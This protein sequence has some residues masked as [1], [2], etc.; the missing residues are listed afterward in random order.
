MNRRFDGFNLGIHTFQE[1]FVGHDSGI[2]SGKIS[3]A[4]A[5]AEVIEID[6]S[7][8]WK[9]RATE[10]PGRIEGVV[11]SGAGWELDFGG[12]E[13]DHAKGDRRA[14]GSRWCAYGVVGR[15][16]LGPC[17]EGDMDHAS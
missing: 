6:G 16:G 13:P 12:F 14:I 4:V 1:S 17:V 10:R 11:G 3:C 9:Y 15:R 7:R 8:C 5:E 2:E